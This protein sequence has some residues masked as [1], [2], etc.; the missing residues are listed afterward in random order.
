[1]VFNT[2]LCFFFWIFSAIIVGRAVMDDA[3][4]AMQTRSTSGNFV[5]ADVAISLS[6]MLTL[7]FEVTKL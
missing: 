1:M 3:K 5:I 4:M 7:N 6:F 2:G